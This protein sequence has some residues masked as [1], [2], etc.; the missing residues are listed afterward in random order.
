MPLRKSVIYRKDRKGVTLKTEIQTDSMC[1]IEFLAWSILLYKIIYEDAV[2]F[3]DEIDRVLN[4]ILAER[5][6]KYIHANSKRGQFIFT[7]H[8]IFHL[9]TSIYMKEQLYFVT[10]HHSILTSE[11]YSLSDF[12]DYR[13]DN[14]KVYNLYLKGILGGVPNG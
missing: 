10:K 14:E 5:V 3:A 12:Y 8:N 4:V 13:Y 11:I 7:T 2:L 9:D 1:V 6:I